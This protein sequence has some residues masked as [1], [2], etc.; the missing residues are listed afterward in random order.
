[1]KTT[2]LKLSDI[3]ILEAELFG[4]KNN[5]TNEIV[6]H[7][8]LSQT[9]TITTRYWLTKLGEIAQ[10]EKK[11]VD[12]LSNDL[13]KELGTVTENGDYLITGTIEKDGETITNPKFVKYND[14][15]NKLLAEEKDLVH[16]EFTLDLFDKIT[17]TENYPTFYNLIEVK[18]TVDAV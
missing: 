14:E 17:T 7:G 13:I 18:P 4:T 3:F 15:M 10:S 11:I 6:T 9:L 8:L 5:Q 12:T 2:K 16:F 1:M